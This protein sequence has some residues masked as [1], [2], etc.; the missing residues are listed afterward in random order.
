MIGLFI[1]CHT[2]TM[3][4]GQ[5]NISQAM[6]AYWQQSDIPTFDADAPICSEGRN[7]GD[8]CQCK[9]CGLIDVFMIKNNQF[10]IDGLFSECPD[11]E[12]DCAG[13]CQGNAKVDCAGVCQGK[14]TKDDC[15]I[16]SGGSSGNISNSNKDCVGVCFGTATRDDCGICSG[17]TS[18]NIP[19]V[20]KDCSGICFGSKKVDCAGV[21]DGTAVID[22]CGICS[23]GT[24]GN[25]SNIDKDC[26][27]ICFGHSKLDCANI[28]GGNAAIDQCGE[29]SNDGTSAICSV[30]DQKTNGVGSC[31]LDP[32]TGYYNK[33]CFTEAGSDGTHK[34]F[35]V[36]G[37]SVGTASKKYERLKG[38][39]KLVLYRPS[40]DKDT[41]IA[42]A[43][44]LA[45]YLKTPSGSS[46][47]RYLG[48]YSMSTDSGFHLY[49]NKLVLSTLS[50]GK[51]D[52]CGDA[53]ST[54]GAST[55]TNEAPCLAV[56]VN[57]NSEED[58]FSHKSDIYYGNCCPISERDCQGHCNGPMVIINNE[59][60]CTVGLDCSNICDGLYKYNSCDNDPWDLAPK[61]I[62]P[63]TVDECA[64]SQTDS[65]KYND[66]VGRCSL[67]KKMISLHGVNYVIPRYNDGRLARKCIRDAGT[68]S[69]G[70]HTFELKIVW[71][72]DIST[73]SYVL[74]PEEDS[75]Y[76]LQLFRPKCSH[77]SITKWMENRSA[78]SIVKKVPNSTGF[79][80]F[81]NMEIAGSGSHS[82]MYGGF[83]IEKG[84]LYVSDNTETNHPT[85]CGDISESYG[86]GFNSIFMPCIGVVRKKSDGPQCPGPQTEEDKY[87]NGIGR[88]KINPLECVDDAGTISIN[89]E[90]LE[91]K[92]VWG[93]DITTASAA[94][95]P[96]PSEKKLELFQPEC[97]QVGMFNWFDDSYYNHTVVKEAMPSYPVKPIYEMRRIDDQMHPE[98][99]AGLFTEN[100]IIYAS[101]NPDSTHPT[102]CGSVDQPADYGFNSIEKPCIAV[103]R[104]HVDG[105]Q[106]PGPQTEEDKY[107]NGIGRCKVN[108]LNCVKEAGT[109]S[110]NGKNVNLQLVWG[111]DITTASAAMFPSPNDKRLELFR[112]K[113]VYTDMMDWIPNVVNDL[114]DLQILSVDNKRH[115]NIDGGL[116]LENTSYLKVNADKAGDHPTFCGDVHQQA[117]DG[118]NRAKGACLAVVQSIDD[119]P[120]CPGRT[121]DCAGELYGN[122]ITDCQGTCGGSLQIG[123]CDQC[124]PNTS[125]DECEVACDDGNLMACHMASCWD[126]NVTACHLAC[127]DGNDGCSRACTLSD[128]L[129]MCK[130]ASTYDIFSA[131]G[132]ICAEQKTYGWIQFCNFLEKH[133]I[134]D[135][136][137]Q[138]CFLACAF[139]NTKTQSCNFIRQQCTSGSTDA[140][141]FIRNQCSNGLTDAC[142]FLSTLIPK[143]KC[144]NTVSHFCKRK[145]RVNKRKFDRIECAEKE[146]L[147]S[148]CCDEI[149]PKTCEMTIAENPNFCTDRNRI[150]KFPLPTS[151]CVNHHCKVREC[152]NVPAPR[153]CRMVAACNYNLDMLVLN[154]PSKCF[155]CGG[156][157]L[158]V[159]Q[160]CACNNGWGGIDC[161]I[162]V[163]HNNIEKR[164][165]MERYVEY[166]RN[167]TLNIDERQDKIKEVSQKLVRASV[168][169]GKSVKESVKENRLEIS[170]DDLPPQMNKIVHNIPRI[171]QSIDNSEF[172]DNCHLGAN[173]SWCATHD[174][175]DD[176]LDNA[177]TILNTGNSVGSWTI[178]VDGSTIV[179]KQTKNHN[180][181]FDMQCWDTTM[182]DWEQPIEL[183]R[184][185]IYQCG[186]YI[187]SIG[188]Q[189]VIC[190]SY[191][192]CNGGS[193]RVDGQT[194]ICECLEG[195]SGP[196]CDTPVCVP[197]NCNNNGTCLDNGDPNCDCPLG[198]SGPTC[199][200]PVCV[201]QY[202]HNGGVC[203][204]SG[205]PN[206]VCPL[207]W[208]GSTCETATCAFT[209]SECNNLKSSFQALDCCGDGN[210]ECKHFKRLYN[211][212]NCCS[213][214]I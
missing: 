212:G 134:Q 87:A 159:D 17:G 148:E 76:E 191:S 83:Y 183:H 88:C 47:E 214:L 63:W 211:C 198:W 91:L 137:L 166:V 82:E 4:Y 155:D 97:S 45:G 1:F 188:S 184:F 177:T 174:L 19:N 123:L 185:D 112:P 73:A 14:A 81:P 110:I 71:G 118:F 93:Q 195:W 192:D 138:A 105:P 79:L 84:K 43:T 119:D 207:G 20:N 56:L 39:G 89:G 167:S 193:C 116:F 144:K 172:D 34:F 136:E 145:G 150:D 94:M 37:Q 171:A 21:C 54:Y 164:E 154:D 68:F 57:T 152:C 104:K 197:K 59:C 176:R 114:G 190:N 15:G 125:P 140:C 203:I 42:R 128:D 131:A 22:D 147:V 33:K 160:K 204:D 199:D 122:K 75:E 3:A 143:T 100:G 126:G 168:L 95:F 146:C 108:P 124:G 36:W 96:S 149:S 120:Q 23:Q 175:A 85:F 142:D 102:F 107:A 24:T 196:T 111:Q 32:V 6:N 157:G 80:S 41:L 70:E 130:K 141:V 26:A 44:E 74:F 98:M 113:C 11:N 115:T 103:V 50:S 7:V 58:Q 189:F 86:K 179:S 2:F 210:S 117:G 162:D 178:I 129:S 170:K 165:R 55:N 205:D 49:G 151:E 13:V 180:G 9:K 16:C 12:I 92:L 61:C 69:D 25:I 161:S 133:C 18:N 101:N 127:E 5:L 8:I 52:F 186:P 35:W 65:E 194:S 182:N 90:N 60:K 64:V 156:N 66:G 173:A 153:D 78:W 77:Y 48:R 46:I 72:Q 53:T 135:E 67:D 206:C 30:E 163:G 121:Y 62:S 10:C 181:T 27:G 213:K 200:T 51:D 132:V 187:L 158:C 109:M 202:C 29:C 208:T 40:C 38:D 99:N 209:S 31:R 169:S 201:P 106:C 28:C 139:S